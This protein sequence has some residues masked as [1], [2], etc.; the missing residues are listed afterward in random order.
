M[1]D[2][3]LPRSFYHRP[4]L[5]VAPD[6]L[7]KIFVRRHRGIIT[8]GRI[9][10]VEAYTNTNDPA[11]HAFRGRTKRNAIMF[12]EPG[13]AYVYFIYGMYYCVNVVTERDGV[14]GACLIRALEPVSGVDIME[15]RRRAEHH[16]DL[17]NGPGKLCLALHID[18][19]L[20]GADLLG[21]DLH[22]V[23]DGFTGFKIRRSPRIG[24]R[25]GTD[26]RY[27]FFIHN[28][29]YVSKSKFNITSSHVNK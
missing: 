14:A 1:P 23:D 6:L 20:N 22:I 18:R 16:Y 3:L 21:N 27:R 25:V 10:E 26:K 24:I 8:S 19:E 5:E 29:P 17:S 13:Y 9:V 7:G 15:K 28:N 12:G 4:T 2:R 11:S